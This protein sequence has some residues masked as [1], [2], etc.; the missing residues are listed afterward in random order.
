MTNREIVKFPIVPLIAFNKISEPSKDLTVFEISS[1]SSFEFNKIT[2]IL[3]LAFDAI[4]VN[5]SGRNTLL[6]DG[7]SKFLANVKQ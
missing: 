5:S 3:S 6:I 1:I 7:V 4:V 2:P